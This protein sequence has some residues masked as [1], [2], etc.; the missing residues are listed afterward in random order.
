[1]SNI[2]EIVKKELFL[3]KDD[4]YQKFQ[5][6]LC[7]GISNILG[8]RVPV[9]RNYAKKLMKT[10]SLHNLYQEIDT[11]YY[12]EI[13]LKGMLIGLDKEKSFEEMLP[14][15]KDFV[16]LIDNWAICDTFCSSLKRFAK[17]KDKLRNFLK[18]YFH[19]SEEFQ[20][21]FGIVMIIYYFLEK[22]YL[23]ENFII[24]DSITSRDYYVEMAL[25]WAIS[26]C[27]VSFYDETLTYLKTSKI[28]SFVYN[29]AISK[30]LD[31]YRV[32]DVRKQELKNLKK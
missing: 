27:L 15:V 5:E 16:P 19:K 2:K 31:S 10:Y 11:Y 20:I 8:V 30:A 26:I 7:P 17:E 18:D 13:M 3:L 14:F 21:R 12:E 9:L 22:D 32:S 25:A 6:K 29:K 1:M 23:E 4:K 24:F 28:S